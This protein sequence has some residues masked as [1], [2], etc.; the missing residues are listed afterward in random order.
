MC[1]IA[2]AVV[3]LTGAGLMM[4]SLWHTQAIDLGFTPDNVLAA[5]IL[6]PSRYADDRAVQLHENVMTR[7]HALPGVSSVAA[8]EYLPIADGHSI[9]SVNIDGAPNQSVSEAPTAMPQKVSPGYFELMR[10]GLVQGRTFTEADRADAP[11]VAVVNET[12]ARRMWPGKSA[13]GGRIRMFNPSLASATVVGIVKDVRSSGFLTEPPPTMYFPVSQGKA[14]AY[15]V[16]SQVWI[17][18]R[19]VGDPRQIATQFRSIV[20]DVEPPRR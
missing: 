16:P 9:W 5:Q 13:I 15:Y 18:A 17:L 4:R 7:I 3:T 11:L 8:V 2:L 20:R 6:P 10:I 12:M 14:T 1:E 19:T